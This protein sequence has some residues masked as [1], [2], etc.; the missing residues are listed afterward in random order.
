[1]FISGVYPIAAGFA[2]TLSRPGGNLT[3]L[4]NFNTRLMAKRLE[5]LQQ[6]VPQSNTV[7]VLVNTNSP[8]TQTIESEVRPA[9]RVLGVRVEFVGAGTEDEID[10]AFAAALYDL[11]WNP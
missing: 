6:L 8:A 4:S 11:S 10:M 9:A 3:G 7:A 5:L 2:A 1:M